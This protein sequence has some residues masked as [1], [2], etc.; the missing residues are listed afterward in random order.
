MEALGIVLAAAAILLT[1]AFPY[2]RGPEGAFP[3]WYL[4]SLMTVCMCLAANQ[5]TELLE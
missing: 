4:L 2:M 3:R 1:L 5:V